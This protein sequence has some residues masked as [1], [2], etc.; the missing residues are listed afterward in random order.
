MEKLCLAFELFHYLCFKPFHQL[1]NCDT[2]TSISTHDRVPFRI[3]LLNCKSFGH[4]TCSCQRKDYSWALVIW[5]LGNYL[6]APKNRT[7]NQG[8]FSVWGPDIINQ[9]LNTFKLLLFTLLEVSAKIITNSKHHIIKNSRSHHIDILSK[10]KKNLEVISN[11]YNR[12]RNNLCLLFTT[13]CKDAIK[14]LTSNI[15]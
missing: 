6:Y 14:N 5:F 2:M 15:Q 9:K 8:F 11:V 1:Q 3:Y 4:E 13:I 12:T 7:L 10:S